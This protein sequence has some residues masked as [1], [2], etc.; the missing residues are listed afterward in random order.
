MISELL[1]H[2]GSEWLRTLRRNKTMFRFIFLQAGSQKL[3]ES[4][5]A[6][7][8]PV[9][10]QA[11]PL[12]HFIPTPGE[13]HGPGAGGKGSEGTAGG[14]SVPRSRGRN[15]CPGT[16]RNPRRTFLPSMVSD[17]AHQGH[18]RSSPVRKPTRLPFLSP[19]I[20]K[21]KARSKAWENALRPPKPELTVCLLL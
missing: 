6:L 18:V 3:R 5:L 20:P 8:D 14:N 12:T 21:S 11:G 7:K 13:P 16:S 2:P 15:S 1:S 10:L 9:S 4:T 19:P 17:R